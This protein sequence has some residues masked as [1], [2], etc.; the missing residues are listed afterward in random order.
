[1]PDPCVVVIFG[2]SG[3]LTSRKLAPVLHN[4]RTEGLI[5]PE[6]AILGTSRTEH[7]DEQ[8]AANLK[9]ALDEYSRIKPTKETW[10]ATNVFYVPGD[11]T[12]EKLY[13]ELGR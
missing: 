1:M 3:D 10:P 13:Q 6:T 9:D 7:R 11:A 4:L 8:F 12:D 2:A 5:P